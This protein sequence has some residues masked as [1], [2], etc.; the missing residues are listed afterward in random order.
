MNGKNEDT[1]FRYLEG[2]LW[3]LKA[4]VGLALKS[5]NVSEDQI[6]E[7][8]ETAR[9]SYM[10]AH[11]D[12]SPESRGFEQALGNVWNWKQ[13]IEGKDEIDRDG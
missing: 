12:R 6:N 10:M 3:A 13:S 11:H 5:G 7:V 8:G 2:Q 4:L 1:R 9:K